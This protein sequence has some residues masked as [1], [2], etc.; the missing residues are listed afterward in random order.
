MQDGAAIAV[1]AKMGTYS[2]RTLGRAP[3]DDLVMALKNPETGHCWIGLVRQPPSDFYIDTKEGILSLF[4][5]PW[6]FHWFTRAIT[7]TGSNQ[8]IDDI[9]KMY[10]KRK[11]YLNMDDT[12]AGATN[13]RDVL[14]VYFFGRVPEASV[15]DP[16][17]IAD[18]RITH[19]QLEVKM[20]SPHGD[21]Q[22]HVWIDLKTKQVTKAYEDGK[23][24][25][26]EE[27]A[28]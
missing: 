12:S 23:Q 3:E 6:G 17:K 28:Q 13:F 19:G 22:A 1:E 5:V 8:S 16:A 27:S 11:E 7:N 26:P 4:N 24:V 18:M 20:V 10:D 21:F 15:E 2:F 14:K 9:I 25:F